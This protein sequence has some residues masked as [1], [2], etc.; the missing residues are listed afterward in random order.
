M[1]KR[2]KMVV[3][4]LL[5][6][7]SFPL[8]AYADK[9]YIN[10]PSTVKVGEVV[11]CEISGETDTEVTSLEANINYGSELSYVSFANSGT[12]IGDASRGLLSLYGGEY[13]GKFKIGILKVKSNGVGNNGI[14]L[15][16]IVFY[17][18][19]QSG[20][21]SK[22]VDS[23]SVNLNV[24]TDQQPN[25]NSNKNSSTGSTSNTTNK[26]SSGSS[27]TD[28]TKSNT[29]SSVSTSKSSDNNIKSLSIDGYT[30]DFDPNVT[31]YNLSIGNDDSL[32]FDLTLS[33]DKAEYTIEG[34][35]E[36]KN[37]SVILIN[38]IAEDESS[39]MYKI[40]IEKEV[41]D[42]NEKTTKNKYVKYIFIAII[43]LL[44]LVNVIRLFK[45]LV[46]K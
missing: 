33:S 13:S 16:S 42:D 11:S 22:K 14:S 12:W 6:M 45:S 19:I 25:A 28:T 17:D 2:I 10:C 3:L 4:S 18:D 9:I 23:V 46:K 30:L 35:S 15:S 29:Q 40:N 31:E 5:V 44:V 26:N 36:L 39:K 34:N 41:A 20:S 32:F 27:K 21:V 7:L 43:V 37:G 38:V 24:V 8:F 1:C